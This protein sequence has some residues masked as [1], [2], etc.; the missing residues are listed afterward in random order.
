MQLRNWL[1]FAPVFGKCLGKLPVKH[2]LYM[3][4]QFRYE[5]PHWVNGRVHINSF[6]P[7]YPSRAFD[8]FLDAVFNRRRVPFSAYFAVTD[9]CPY[10]CPHCS[11][12]RHVR[13]SLDTA[14]AVEII[15]QIRSI[16]TITI[17]FTGG[18]PLMRKDI[19]DL[20]RA[21]GDDTATVMFSTGYKLNSDLAAKLCDAG[22]DCM[23]IGIESDDA[24]E[25]D[26]I[27]GVLGSYETALS[28]IDMSLAA[29]LYTAISTVASRNKLQAGTLERLAELAKGGGVHEFRILEPIPT[30][31]YFGC[32][33]EIL[34]AEESKQLADFHKQYNRSGQGPAIAS[35]AH[36]ESD[37]MFGC[38]A[39]FHHV[40]VDALGNVC[41]CD[42][43]PLAIGNVL[44]EP[45]YDIWCR[46]SRWFELP[47]RGCFMKR[48][49]TETN[50]LGGQE[51]FPLCCEESE[52]LC[53]QL[54][55]DGTLPTIFENLFKG[56][57][58]TNPPVSRP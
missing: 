18:E 39:G 20:V 4:K 3:A 33:S 41:P 47:R 36:L 52:T 58:P 37:A 56:R 32:E 49:C 50:A 53:S 31:S 16:G 57:K 46:M 10:H 35:F 7:P 13:G 44:E 8:R 24:A 25:H 26:R 43:T 40:F 27:R 5:N 28:A 38:G 51:Q 17:G 6:F 19:A 45:L 2:L 55:N 11:Y 48:L 21:A 29:G 12:G 15:R 9:R 1:K 14:R 23:T 30:G 34:T 22:L 54:A 42:L